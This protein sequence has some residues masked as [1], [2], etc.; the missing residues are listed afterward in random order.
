[1]GDAHY[2]VEKTTRS[3]KTQTALKLLSEE[4]RI[5]AIATM[6]DGNITDKSMEHAQEMIKRNQ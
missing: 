2:K 3:G 1:M 6:T 4:E 5:E